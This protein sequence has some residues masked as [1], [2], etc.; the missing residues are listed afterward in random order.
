MLRTKELDSVQP[1]PCTSLVP[2]DHAE[3]TESQSNLTI[4]DIHFK[5]F[6]GTTSGKYKNDV[7]TIVCSSPNVSSTLYFPGSGSNGLGLLRHLRR[8]HQREEPQGHG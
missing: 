1:V 5:N 8:E 7:G 2:N 3:L 4:S 6:Q